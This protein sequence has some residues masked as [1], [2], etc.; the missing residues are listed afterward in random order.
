MGE[1]YVR[2]SKHKRK[3]ERPNDLLMYFSQIV[4][5]TFEN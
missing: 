1:F 4:I 5:S 3:Q 2:R